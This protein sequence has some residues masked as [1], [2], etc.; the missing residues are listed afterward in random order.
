VVVGRVE[1]Q[2][3]SRRM[4]CDEGA[5]SFSLSV[6]A[7]GDVLLGRSVTFEYGDGRLRFGDRGFSSA[8][9]VDLG[10]DVE[11]EL[12]F[13][14]GDNEKAGALV[15]IAGRVL[16]KEM[17]KSF[18]RLRRSDCRRKASKSGFWSSGIIRGL[19]A[20]VDRTREDGGEKFARA[21]APPADD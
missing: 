3:P 14:A 19:I 18:F 6:N 10:T 16:G 21:W 4:Y 11:G 15:V 17:L 7:A 5:T 20:A 12:G 1:L 13:H 2:F 9:C 8:K